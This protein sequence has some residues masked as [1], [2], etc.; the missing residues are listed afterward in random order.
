MALVERWAWPCKL[1]SFATVL[2][3][4]SIPGRI[5]RTLGRTIGRNRSKTGQTRPNLGCSGLTS[6]RARNRRS[7][8]CKAE[9]GQVRP[10]RPNSTNYGLSSAD[11][12]PRLAISPISSNVG[13]EST[14]LGRRSAEVGPIST[15]PLSRLL[16]AAREAGPGCARE[17]RHTHA[18]SMLVHNRSWPRAVPRSW[19]ARRYLALDRVEADR[20][21]S[22]LGGS[23]SKLAETGPRPAE[24]G[25]T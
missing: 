6:A 22:N 17:Q 19:V 16:G 5:W 25:R 13:P 9:F 3:T 24:V 2:Q 11:V 1:V 14:Q 4:W 20:R 12:G 18:R 10:N 15:D 7:M 8:Q 23:G 21:R